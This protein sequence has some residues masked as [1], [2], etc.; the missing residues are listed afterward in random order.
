MIVVL[1]TDIKQQYTSTSSLVTLGIIRILVV[2][3]ADGSSVVEA[4]LGTG[5][6]FLLYQVIVRYPYARTEQLNR[7]LNGAAALVLVG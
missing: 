2:S 4:F 7:A 5:F 3:F 6:L 1:P